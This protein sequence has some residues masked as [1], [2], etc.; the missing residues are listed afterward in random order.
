GQ[1]GTIG[2]N[3]MW[4]GAQNVS[5]VNQGTITADVAYGTLA[6]TAN[7]T[8]QGLLSASLGNLAMSQTAALANGAITVG[9]AGP[10]TY[11]RLTFGNSAQLGGLLNIALSD[12]YLSVVGDSFSV[13]NYPSASGTFQNITLPRR[14]LY[15]GVVYGPSALNLSV[16][17]YIAPAVAITS[18]TN[19]QSFIAPLNLPIQVTATD[20]AVAI[21][22]VAFF[23]DTTK[24]GDDA[25]S[26]YSLTWS[27]VPP[28]V[29]ALTAKATDAVK[30]ET[31]SSSV[32]ITV[33]PNAS[34]TNYVWVGGASSSWATAQNWNP[35]G[36]P[37]P[38]DTASVLNGSTV[39]LPGATTVSSFNLV[40]GTLSGPG[41]L[42]ISNAFAWA[43]ARWVAR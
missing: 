17:N 34:G 1:T 19:N 10:Q 28:G 27:N 25:N 15:W 29:Y 3:Q 14:G 2:Y 8:N 9:I 13:V 7:L 32:I 39:T 43:G 24:L 12:D 35:T 37:G 41:S 36:V 4:G 40:S 31:A 30:A 20:A 11:G 22:N 5:V 42:T 16:T 18:P 38:Q 23:A 26:P 6:I 33:F 21:T